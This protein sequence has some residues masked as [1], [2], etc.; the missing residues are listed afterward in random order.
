MPSP[1]PLFTTL[2]E[3]QMTTFFVAVAAMVGH[4]AS[5]VFRSE[6]QIVLRSWTIADEMIAELGRRSEPK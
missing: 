5:P 6:Q 3:K 4:I 2:E 1:L